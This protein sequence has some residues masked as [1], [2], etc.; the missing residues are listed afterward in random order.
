MEKVYCEKCVVKLDSRRSPINE[1]RNTNNSAILKTYV[2]GYGYGYG[3]A[4]DGDAFVVDGLALSGHVII[5]GVADR[6]HVVTDLIIGQN[7]A[8]GA[9]QGI[10]RVFINETDGE[11]AEIV[12]ES[13]LPLTADF[14]SYLNRVMRNA[15]GQNVG[16]D[17]VVCVYGLNIKGTIL[18]YTRNAG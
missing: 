17:V 6:A 18:Y 1:D 10:V 7:L 8:K 4:A 3:Y 2:S 15:D 14:D 12:F 16:T 11:N 5:P 9:D 13:R